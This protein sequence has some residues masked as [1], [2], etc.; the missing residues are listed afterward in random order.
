METIK[1]NINGMTCGGCV[2]SATKA[3]ENVSGVD[4][5][6]VSLESNSAEVSFNPTQTNADA[7][8]EAVEDAGFDCS[9]A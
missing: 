3:L 1:L 4:K 9:V 2:S 7:L 6:L 5:A 8:V